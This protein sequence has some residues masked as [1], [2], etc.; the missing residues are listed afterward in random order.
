MTAAF[1]FF[2]AFAYTLLSMFAENNA[3]IAMIISQIWIVGGIISIGGNKC[4]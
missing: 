1:C 4:I 3:D 2:F